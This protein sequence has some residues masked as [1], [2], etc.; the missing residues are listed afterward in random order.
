MKQAAAEF[1]AGGYKRI[2][3]THAIFDQQEEDEMN[4]RSAD[5]LVSV[6]VKDGVP[7][8]RIDTVFFSV[9]RKDRT[10]HS[11]LVVKQWLGQHGLSAT[12]LDVASISC[13]ARRSRLLY[14]KAF[15][16]DVRIGVIALQDTQYDPARWWTASEG[17]REVLS[18][19]I[20]Y[21]Y[22][23]LL[24]HPSASDFRMANK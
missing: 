9:V 22:A 19:G 2:L 20:A 11:A 18:E 13:H 1:W 17:V 16:K 4:P 23:R 14:E 15:G 6:L 24:F 7:R 8:D 10:F 3:V 12:A 5:Y 21:L